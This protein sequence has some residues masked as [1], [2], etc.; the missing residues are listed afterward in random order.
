[1]RQTGFAI[2]K[3]SIMLL[4]ILIMPAKKNYAQTPTDAIMMNKGQLCFD[5]AYHHDSWKEYWE[6]TKKRENGNIGTLTKHSIAPMFALGITDRINFMGGL[7][8]IMTRPSAGQIEGTEGFQNLNLAVKVDALDMELGPGRLNILA[9]VG[10]STP[11][12]DYVPDYAYSIGLGCT[13]G[14]LRPIVQYKLNNGLFARV[15]AGYNLRS[16]CTLP[17]DYYYTTQAYFSNEVDMPDAIDYSATIGYETADAAFRAE[18]FYGGLN[19]LGG[20]DIRVQD[21]GFPSNNMDMTNIGAAVHYYPSI[22]KGLGIH[23]SGSYVLTGRNV[24][25][26]TSIGG[27]VSY[28]FSLWNKS[29]N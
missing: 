17:R 12:S 25:Q 23:A 8:Y 22:V 5:L 1:M 27:S 28:Y 26:T 13:E 24:G 6:G 18:A 16:S 2:F 21:M 10:F 7:S 19:T 9:T 14:S 3:F 11:I 4:A 15:Q 29:N 20:F